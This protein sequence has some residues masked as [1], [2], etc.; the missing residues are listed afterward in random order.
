M[1]DTMYD[2]IPKAIRVQGGKSAQEVTTATLKSVGKNVAD[3]IVGEAALSLINGK[4][5]TGYE[6]PSGNS[7]YQTSY[8]KSSGS[9]AYQG[10][11][12]TVAYHSV[13]GDNSAKK[14]TKCAR[15]NRY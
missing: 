12:D 14:K 2:T 3:N 7:A 13:G 4:L 10:G 1:L 9:F 8:G 5:K 11:S 15:W 6:K